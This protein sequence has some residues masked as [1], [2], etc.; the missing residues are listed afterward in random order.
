MRGT[1]EEAAMAAQSRSRKREKKPAEK[2]DSTLRNAKHVRQ[3]RRQAIRQK[4]ER[5]RER[6]RESGRQRE[7]QTKP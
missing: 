1:T 2:R 3:G 7:Q 4:R 6:E 5:E